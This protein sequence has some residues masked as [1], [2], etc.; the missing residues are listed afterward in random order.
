MENKTN[1]KNMLLAAS[2]LML[3]DGVVSAVISLVGFAMGGLFAANKGTEG[4]GA[5][6]S[7]FIAYSVIVLLMAAFQIIASIFG[8]VNRSNP[9]KAHA[10]FVMGIILVLIAVFS[11]VLS[12][13]LKSFQV[14][15]IFSL[16]LP[17]LYVGGAR[18]N[19][20]DHS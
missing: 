8:I 7:L 2:I 4:A 5:L 16:V 6:A 1:G 13:Y 19:R 3:I 12:L 9:K 15:Q 20:P 10:C 17:L 14:M 18:M 11:I